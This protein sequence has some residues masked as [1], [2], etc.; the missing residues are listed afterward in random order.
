M[1]ESVTANV[2]VKANVWCNPQEKDP[3]AIPYCL[4][5]ILPGDLL[6]AFIGDLDART[7][8]RELSAEQRREFEQSRFFQRHGQE[9]KAFE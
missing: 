2:G 6:V 7:L 5:E 3:K 4:Q 8:D 1:T 9:G